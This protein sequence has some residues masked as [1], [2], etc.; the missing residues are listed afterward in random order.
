M[1]KGHIY[2]GSFSGWYSVSDEAFI[3]EMQVGVGYLGILLFWG[4]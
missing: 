2:K 4:Y 1:E 3:P